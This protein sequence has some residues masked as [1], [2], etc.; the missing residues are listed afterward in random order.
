MGASLTHECEQVV[1]NWSRNKQDAKRSA[2]ALVLL[3][4]QDASSE[5]A[6][7]ENLDL[8]ALQESY[9]RAFKQSPTW[10]SVEVNAEDEQK[11]R[12]TF[13]HDGRTIIG[14]WERGKN[15]AKA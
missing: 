9:Q 11:F 6:P 1:G 4:F 7:S 2:L 3:C 8:K 14:S 12:A 10:E 15:L 5:L 13:C